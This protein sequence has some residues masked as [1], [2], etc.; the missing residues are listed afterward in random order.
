ME[1]INKD[2]NYAKVN[3]FIEAIEQIGKI[4]KVK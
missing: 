4:E 1:I 2:E 3:V